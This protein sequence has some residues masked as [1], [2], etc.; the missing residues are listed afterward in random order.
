MQLESWSQNRRHKRHK[1]SCRVGYVVS[2]L[3]TDRIPF[4]ILSGFLTS[5]AHHTL[6]WAAPD[7]EGRS[8][9][10]EE[11]PG[12]CWSTC[13]FN[14]VSVVHRLECFFLL[15]VFRF[16][17]VG[18]LVN[19]CPMFAC[20]RP[21]VSLLF[22]LSLHLHLEVCFLGFRYQQTVFKILRGL[23]LIMVAW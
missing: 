6:A 12:G 11:E 10:W 20:F 8:Q 18:M 19:H 7:W 3:T 2:M 16:L 17:T 4:Q 9:F 15:F 5:L 14:G 13:F 22:Q 1:Y 21:N 23:F